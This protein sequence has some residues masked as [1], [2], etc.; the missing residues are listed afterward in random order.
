MAAA[1]SVVCRKPGVSGATSYLLVEKK[2]QY[3]ANFQVG[4][5]N[6]CSAGEKGNSI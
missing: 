4:V 5:C 1:R 6:H 2:Q 3:S